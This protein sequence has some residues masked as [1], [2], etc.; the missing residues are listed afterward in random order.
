VLVI[1]LLV[2]LMWLVLMG[3]LA[4]WT[5]WFQGY[6][7]TQ[8]V[9]QLYWRAPAAGTALTLFLIF[10]IA[11]DY[12]SVKNNPDAHFPYGPIQELAPSI[13]KSDTDPFPSLIVPGENNTELEYKLEKGTDARK[14]HVE[15]RRYGQM[16]PSSPS[17]I[18]VVENG[19]RSVFE[20]EK[21]A[22]GH[23]I[24]ASGQ[25]LLYRDS[26]GRVLTE[27]PMFERRSSFPIWR[28]LFGVFLNFA[29]LGVWFACLW[30][31]LNYQMW[32][33]VGLA[34]VIT[35]VMLLF[36][37]APVMSRVEDVAR[38]PPVVSSEPRS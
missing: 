19:E 7:Y 18:I 24:R 36:I 25:P 3:F 12:R 38:P 5:F 10:W 16:L 17:K 22:K 34:V 13:A 26:K 28:F 15:Y 8:P 2:L 32:H 33:A 1:V 27:G 14:G 35:A 37:L 9:D 23:F 20:P 30:L 29:F 21:D 31:L 6:L 11:I 4:A